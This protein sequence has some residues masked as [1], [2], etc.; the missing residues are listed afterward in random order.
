MDTTLSHPGA[1]IE[2]AF[3]A[4]TRHQGHPFPAALIEALNLGP[5]SKPP[6]GFTGKRPVLKGPLPEQGASINVLLRSALHQEARQMR[7][8]IGKQW[9]AYGSQGAPGRLGGVARNLP[10]HRDQYMV[11][12]LIGSG[13]HSAEYCATMPLKQ[14][15]VRS[16][17]FSASSTVLW[18][19]SLGAWSPNSLASRLSTHCGATCRRNGR[20]GAMMA[21]C[22]APS[23][24]S[25]PSAS[26]RR[27]RASVRTAPPRRASAATR[28]NIASSALV[29]ALLMAVSR[30]SSREETPLL[31]DLSRAA[32]S[33]IRQASS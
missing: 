9:G 30:G 14:P 28:W 23:Q 2:A 19:R 33:T 5:P 26:S 20:R 4:F 18:P 24:P 31:L 17:H 22:S 32:V 21:R 16:A 8:H 11:K 15:S 1:R 25:R 12:R 6:E 13:P 3:R 10:Q 29:H 7:T 27:S